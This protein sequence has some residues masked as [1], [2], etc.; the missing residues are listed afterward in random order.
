MAPYS[1]GYARADCPGH[2]IEGFDII[3]LLSGIC[4]WGRLTQDQLE[5]HALLVTQYVSLWIVFFL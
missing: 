4:G 2:P 5:S 3:H 1:A